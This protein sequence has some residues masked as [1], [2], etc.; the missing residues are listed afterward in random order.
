VTTTARYIIALTHHQAQNMRREKVKRFGNDDRAVFAAR[1]WLRE[2]QFHE[3]YFGIAFSRYEVYKQRESGA[4]FCFEMGDVQRAESSKPTPKDDGVN[5]KRSGDCKANASVG[6][7]G[8]GVPDGLGRAG[9]LGTGGGATSRRKA[10]DSRPR[11][12]FARR[13]REMEEIARQQLNK[14]S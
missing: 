7:P 5:A 14:Q 12:A 3:R 9:G 10:T 4:W 2:V 13:I 11:S 8:P 6:D 1:K